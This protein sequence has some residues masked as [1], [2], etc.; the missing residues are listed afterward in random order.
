MNFDWVTINKTSGGSGTTTLQ[1]SANKNN[2]STARRLKR[3]MFHD[4]NGVGRKYI[5]IYQDPKKLVPEPITTPFIGC[6]AD[7]N[8]KHVVEEYYSDPFQVDD[9]TPINFQLN[10]R[11]EVTPFTNARL[12]V[13]LE[14]SWGEVFVMK[15]YFIEGGNEIYPNESV[16]YI[17]D[18]HGTYKIRISMIANADTFIRPGTSEIGMFGTTFYFS[19]PALKKIPQ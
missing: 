8:N 16:D 7:L 18:S 9:F 15:E 14:S 11:I 13:S 12:G 2:T 4:P 1:V 19:E 10:A 6:Y 17:I 5:E 3:F